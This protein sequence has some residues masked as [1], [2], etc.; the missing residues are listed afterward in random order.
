MSDTKNQE[1]IN[2]VEFMKARFILCGHEWGFG[3]CCDVFQADPPSEKIVQDFL[4]SEFRGRDANY[5]PDY[6]GSVAVR[7]QAE[8]AKKAK[9]VEG[10]KAA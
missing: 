4:Q 10:D 5:V 9:P 8:Q 3:S 7:I 2:L 1:L 6:G